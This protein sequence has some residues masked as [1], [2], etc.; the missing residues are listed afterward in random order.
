M[1]EVVL[2]HRDTGLYL[3]TDG[4]W[5]HFSRDAL[6]FISTADALRFAEASEMLALL[7]PVVR[8]RQE[9]HYVLMPLLD[10]DPAGQPCRRQTSKLAAP[11]AAET[12]I[13][14]RGPLPH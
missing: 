14:S 11:A 1:I 3:S 6:V 12:A 8:V 7:R 5:A 10:P 9:H 13:K 2:Q 4:G